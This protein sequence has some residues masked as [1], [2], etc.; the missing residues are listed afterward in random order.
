MLVKH[1]GVA[2]FRI[3]AIAQQGFPFEMLR[4]MPQLLFDVRKLG[5]K[6]VLLG[7]LRGAQASIQSFLGHSRRVIRLALRI[8]AACAAVNLAGSCPSR[9]KKR[10]QSSFTSVC[11]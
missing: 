4:V 6:L 11:R 7:R 10:C 2:D 1:G 9:L 5:V 8:Q 3:V